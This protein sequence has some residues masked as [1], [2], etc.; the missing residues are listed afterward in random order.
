MTDHSTL[1]SSNPVTSVS[2]N[3]SLVAFDSDETAGTRSR[4]L[5]LGTLLTWLSSNLSFLTGV[6]IQDDGVSQGSV[7]TINA[8]GGTATV[9]G[10]VADISFPGSLYP[11]AGGQ[12]VP[13]GT[14]AYN[15]ESLTGNVLIGSTWTESSLDL[16]TSSGV[17]LGC[18]FWVRS[19]K[20]GITIGGTAL[21][22]FWQGELL[23]GG[24]A[25][26]FTR[27]AAGTMTAIMKYVEPKANQNSVSVSTSR[28]IAASDLYTTM[29][30]TGGSDVELTLPNGIIGSDR[31]II[32]FG[33][34]QSATRLLKVRYRVA[35]PVPVQFLVDE[36]VQAGLALG[37]QL[38]RG[39]T[40]LMVRQPG[41][42][43]TI[44]A[45]G[46]WSVYTPT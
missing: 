20:D 35:D 10:S 16:N 43:N 11:L 34:M 28:D 42:S 3:E 29:I 18:Q 26:L 21:E 36:D 39:Q 38:K 24:E 33:S 2:G 23:N 19:A 9:V 27:T 1:H 31:A 30:A 17:P 41:N 45:A 5:G 37:V 46:G 44:F 13:N 6:G 32:S 4:A 14:T 22:A 40:G 7:T 25:L 12:Y 8:V 15:V